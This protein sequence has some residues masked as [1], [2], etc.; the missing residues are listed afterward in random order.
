MSKVGKFIIITFSVVL[1]VFI[2]SFAYSS[3]YEYFMKSFYPLKYNDYV[4]EASNKYNVEPSLIYGIIKTES[5]FDETAES[6]AGAIGLMQIMPETFEWLQTYTDDEYMTKNDLYSPKNNI[7]YG[8]FFISYLLKKYKT[9]REAICAY[10]AGMGNVDKWLKNP[11]YSSDGKT[12]DYI[13]FTES[14]NYVEKVLKSRD[15]YN[16]LY[17]KK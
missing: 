9:E 7:N 16:K 6:N 12:L 4:T 13:P 8:T 1:V 17:Y 5:E 15:M 3:G 14:R 2:A 10:N 11:D